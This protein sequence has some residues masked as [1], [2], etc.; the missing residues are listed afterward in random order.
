MDE[1][2]RAGLHHV[3]S[4]HGVGGDVTVITVAVCRK[5]KGLPGLGTTYLS[6]GIVEECGKGRDGV[7]ACR[8]RGLKRRAEENRYELLERFPCDRRSATVRES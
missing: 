2:W 8:R 7:A 6:C 1:T 4:V 3:E 5:N